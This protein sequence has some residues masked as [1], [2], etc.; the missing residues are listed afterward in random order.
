M[1]FFICI[2]NTFNQDLKD[3]QAV[4]LAQ[5]IVGYSSNNKIFLV[6]KCCWSFRNRSVLVLLFFRSH[7]SY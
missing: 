4:S 3:L 5:K 2:I 7:L 6:S 1:Y